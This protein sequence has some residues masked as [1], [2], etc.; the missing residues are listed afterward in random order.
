MSQHFP[1]LMKSLAVRRELDPHMTDWWAETGLPSIC[2][3]LAPGD[4]SQWKQRS[5][6]KNVF[7]GLAKEF[8]RDFA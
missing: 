6:E 7:Q 3:R 5:V 2:H 4:I 8:T 1:L